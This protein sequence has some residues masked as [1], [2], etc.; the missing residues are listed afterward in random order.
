MERKPAW[1]VKRVSSLLDE[2]WCKRPWDITM[3]RSLCR[4]GAR[5]GVE[6]GNGM[7]VRGQA[8]MW[9]WQLSKP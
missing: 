3:Y 5:M 8:K 4:Q 9:I 7:K 1:D 6:A 2:P